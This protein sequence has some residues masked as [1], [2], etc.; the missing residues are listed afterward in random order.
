MNMNEGQ[1]IACVSVSVAEEA[2]V[3]IRN[4]AARIITRDM[5]VRTTLLVTMHHRASRL[6]LCM[7]S[8]NLSHLVLATHWPQLRQYFCGTG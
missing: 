1:G 4:G 3:L 8:S 2:I 7:T 5:R 6:G